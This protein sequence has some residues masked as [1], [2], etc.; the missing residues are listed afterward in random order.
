MR[1]HDRAILTVDLPESGLQM[2]DVG[3]IVHIYPDKAAYEVEFFTLDGETLDV[4]TLTAS[5]VRSAA[6]TEILHV[7]SIA[8]PEAS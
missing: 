3:T 7:R 8:I 4:L 2:G 1:E 6:R 5:Q